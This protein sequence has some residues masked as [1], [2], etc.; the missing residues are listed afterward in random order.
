M[1]L[2][3]N[4]KGE[5]RAIQNP[6]GRLCDITLRFM[7]IPNRKITVAFVEIRKLFL[8]SQKSY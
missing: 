4:N 5:H 6:V 3:R 1:N 8:E 2:I 7:R